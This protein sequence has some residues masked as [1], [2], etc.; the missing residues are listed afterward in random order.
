MKDLR[1]EENSF[2]IVTQ[3]AERVFRPGKFMIN[4]I[5]GHRVLHSDEFMGTAHV[6]TLS[7]DMKKVL[8]VKNRRKTDSDNPKPA[9]WG[10]PTGS[11]ELGESPYEAAWRELRE[12]SAK[13]PEGFSPLFDRGIGRLPL[14]TK[15]VPPGK[16]GN[17]SAENYFGEA[18]FVGKIINSNLM[19]PEGPY[20]VFDVYKKRVTE[21]CWV[22]LNELP[23]SVEMLWAG[24]Q[25][26]EDLKKEGLEPEEDEIVFH[27]GGW[28]FHGTPMYESHWRW[29]LRAAYE[30]DFDVLEN[31]VKILI[32]KA[33]E[34]GFHLPPIPKDPTINH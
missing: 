27:K 11:V 7:Y 32:K 31:N 10:C 21:A 16:P 4:L 33:A 8:I 6:V 18:W 22:E 9:G 14:Y 28:V 1:R 17:R 26:L 24:W 2:L 25:I 12:E 30:T 5:R 29:I 23:D 34:F 13:F 15:V 20:D 19:L 3:M